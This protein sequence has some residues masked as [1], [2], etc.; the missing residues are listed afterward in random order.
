MMIKLERIA[1]QLILSGI[2]FEFV[3]GQE[4]NHIRVGDLKLFED[5]SYDA[6]NR[7]YIHTT[8]GKPYTI[9]Y[10]HLVDHLKEV[11]MK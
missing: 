6:E 7:V 11:T 9:L 5:D 3:I 10:V 4:E 2:P 8:D 1:I